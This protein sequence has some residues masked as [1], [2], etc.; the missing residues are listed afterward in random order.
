MMMMMMT[1]NALMRRRRR[2]HRSLYQITYFVLYLHFQEVNTPMTEG[3][4]DKLITMLDQ[5]GDGEVDL[6]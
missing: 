6:K 4:L 5:D 2:R 1:I 3:E